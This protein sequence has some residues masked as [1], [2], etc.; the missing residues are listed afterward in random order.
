MNLTY[1]R[2]FS[3][4]RLTLGNASPELRRS[5]AVGVRARL[6]GSQDIRKFGTKSNFLVQFGARADRQR[7][8]ELESGN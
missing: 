1:L 5:G 8:G 7:S 4:F 6:C 2:Q 3:A